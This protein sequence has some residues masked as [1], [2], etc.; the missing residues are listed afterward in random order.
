MAI[1]R[2]VSNESASEATGGFAIGTIYFIP[3]NS[4]ESRCD[5][6][7]RLV[8]IRGPQYAEFAAMHPTRQ[9]EGLATVHGIDGPRHSERV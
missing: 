7:A 5:F 3:R 1:D 2:P 9:P 4:G 6:E 8:A